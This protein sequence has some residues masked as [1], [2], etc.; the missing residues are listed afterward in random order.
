[1]A[2][3]TAPAVGPATG[4]APGNHP[5]TLVKSGETPSV[6]SSAAALAP[7]FPSGY[8]ILGVLGRGGMGVVYK[9]RQVG[10]NRLV[11]L[12]M[13]LAG[14]HASAE[15]LLRFK[16]E[17]EAVARLQHPNIVGIFDVGT[18]DGRPYFSLEFC[19]GGSLQQKL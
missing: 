4:Q 3:P 2:R 19:E 15:E 12:K 14:S 17:A 6:T 8:Q 11:A 10:L 18:R 9:A 1:L 5:E 16:I 13:V 7:D